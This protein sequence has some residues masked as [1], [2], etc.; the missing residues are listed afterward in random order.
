MSRL[1]FVKLLSVFGLIFATHGL[2]AATTYE[3]GTCKAGFKTFP[4]ITLALLALPSPN[5]V[6]VCPGTYFEQVQITFPVSIE[7]IS[8]NNQARPIVAPPPNGMVINATD[9]FGTPLAAQLVATNVP[10]TVNVSD[11]TFD[12]RGQ[13]VNPAV[14]VGVVYQNSPGTINHVTTRN[15]NGPSFP[16]GRGMLIE[17]GPTNP[18]V[19]VENNSVHDFTGVGMFIDTNTPTSQLT[20]TVTGNYVD[21]PVGGATYG[22]YLI[23]GITATVTNNVVTNNGGYGI[24]TSDTIAGSVT[25]N[26]LVNN[27]IGIRAESD[28]VAITSNKVFSSTMQGILIAAPHLPAIQSNTIVGNLVGIEFFCQADPNVHSNTILDTTTGLSH[29]PTAI[30]STNSYFSVD[31]IRTGGC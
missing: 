23:S 7:G 16:A 24:W 22:I 5:V 26:T 9:S 29:V 4:T 2:W 20:T 31:T 18:T 11:V 28:T 27:A 19:A 1:S 15:Q 8:A 21:A 6:L 12:A 3:V 30:V 14:T 13:G 17:G 25:T 10:G